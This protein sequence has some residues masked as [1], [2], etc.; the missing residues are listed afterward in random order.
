M[1]LDNFLKSVMTKSGEQHT[2]T[3][4]GDKNLNIMGGSYSIPL[5]KM[6]EFY[7]IYKKHVFQEGKFAFLTEKQMEEGPIL[8]DVDFRYTCDV[9]TK[10]HNINH[11]CQLLDCILEGIKNIKMLTDNKTIECYVFEKENVNML[12]DKTKDGIHLLINL[13]MDYK[14][15]LLL[16]KHLLKEMPEIWNDLPIQ[17]SWQDVFDESVVK[18]Y[19]NW[20]LYGSR[21]PG[22]ESYQLKHRFVCMYNNEWNIKES[23]VTHDWIVSNF[24]KLTA[25][26]TDLV[27][28]PLN[29]EVEEEYNSMDLSK[30]KTSTSKFKLQENSIFNTK[31]PFDIKTKEELDEYITDFLETYSSTTDN[32]LHE[33]HQYVM[34]L[35]EEYWGP[36]SYPKRMRVGWALRNIDSRLFVT[37]L[38]FSVQHVD[39]DYSQIPDL[40]E[41]WCNFDYNKE[42]LSIRSIIYWCKL[43]NPMEFR[44]IYEKTIT[45]YIIYA[46]GTKKEYDLAMVLYQMYKDRFVCASYKDKLWYEFKNN[47][48]VEIDSGHR[49]LSM[50]STEVYRKFKEMV[51][52]SIQN[53]KA[54]QAGDQHNQEKKGANGPAETAELLKKTS[55]K[56]NIMKEAQEIFY[57]SN[58]MENLD[59]NPYLLGCNN[60]VIDFKEKIHRKGR[61]DDYLSL[62]TNIEYYPL[63]YIKESPSAKYI[64]EINEF[65]SQVYP[66]ESVREY[67]WEHLASTLI[68]TNPNQSFYIYVGSGANGKSMLVDFMTKVLGDYKGTVPI[69]LITQKRNSIGTTSSEVY[70]LK[71]VRYAVMQEPSKGDV[72]NEGIMKEIT[73]GDPIQCRALYKESVTFIPQFKLCAGT[74]TLL[75][76]KSQDD[77]TWRRFQQIEHVSKFIDNPYEDEMFSR[78]DYPYQFKKDKNLKDKFDAW[79]PVMLS[80]L[81]DIAYRTNGIVKPCAIIDAATQKYRQSQDVHLEFINTCIMVHD[82][83]QPKKLKITTINDAFK[84][85]YGSNHGNS[86]SKVPP[87]KDLKEYLIKKFGSYPKDG[88]AKLSL[89]ETEDD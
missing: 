12:E 47:R 11:V 35:P 67:M 39:F 60:C 10:Q 29:P 41:Q 31:M 64:D 42:G 77:G 70:Q 51:V 49:L 56:A 63:S 37:W 16:R 83:P 52:S 65:M 4:I 54:T 79:A 14:C 72:I 55:L 7:R 80:M 40:Y 26:N 73:G 3:K 61:H 18:G 27:S 88:W 57:D 20:Q 75:E 8:I 46:S 53:S 2:H 23:P 6:D 87:L 21:K 34:A 69:T 82:M 44:R 5:E 15:K 43:S 13:K 9:D 66:I 38:K 58:F 19:S 62:S 68:G 33:A 84:N 76:V 81:V 22:N 71:G 30:K 28:L 78:E 50:I 48:W 17:N 45:N 74:N 36:G 1:S 86:G 32:I 24:I 85:W 59:T 89:I 25:R